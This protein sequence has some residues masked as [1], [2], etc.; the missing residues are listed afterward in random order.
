MVS[1][2]NTSISATER[3]S[4]EW[5]AS[6]VVQCGQF[7]T[8][9]CSWLT[10][11]HWRKS[12]T[13][14]CARGSWLLRKPEVHPCHLVSLG[15]LARFWRVSWIRLAILG[16]ISGRPH[17]MPSAMTRK[18]IVVVDSAWLRMWEVF[19]SVWIF[20]VPPRPFEVSSRVN[21]YLWWSFS[22]ACCHFVHRAVGFRRRNW[23]VQ[24]SSSI[25]SIQCATG[26][27]YTHSHGGKYCW[28]ETAV[29]LRASTVKRAWVFECQPRSIFLNHWCPSRPARRSRCSIWLQ[30]QSEGKLLL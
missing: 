14:M 30:W 28:T 12:C 2:V 19:N 20:W 11:I 5:S 24:K 13:R 16:T 1:P 3:V 4:E 17:A 9:A 22:P 15:A 26:L 27:A 25:C 21:N 8:C 23:A 6:E 18:Y 7:Q 29:E 10:T